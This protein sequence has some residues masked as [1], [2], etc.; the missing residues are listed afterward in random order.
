M[1]MK[2]MLSTLTSP[3]KGLLPVLLGLMAAVLAGATV[4]EAL[5]GA[6]VSRHYVY[7]SLWFALLWAAVAAVSLLR[8]WRVAKPG[9]RPGLRTTAL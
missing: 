4:V 5:W 8:L 7:H 2:R 9:R 1:H 6:A 3:E